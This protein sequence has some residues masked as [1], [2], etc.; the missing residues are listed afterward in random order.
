[1]QLQHCFYNR[2]Q[3]EDDECVVAACLM[4]T[5]ST[6]HVWLVIRLLVPQLSTST[7][8][9]TTRTAQRLSFSQLIYKTVPSLLDLAPLIIGSISML[10]L[11]VRLR[12]L[13]P[14]NINDG[15]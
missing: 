9:I 11:I 13:I 3:E 4:G 12:N 2:Y 8:P 6:N 15:D 1:M 14:H 7:M 10:K 5:G